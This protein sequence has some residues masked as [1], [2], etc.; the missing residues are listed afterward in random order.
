MYRRCGKGMID[1]R[2]RDGSGGRDGVP[3][4]LSTNLTA[5][6]LRRDLISERPGEVRLGPDRIEW[7]A[8][9]FDWQPGARG[10]DCLSNFTALANSDD[11]D[12]FVEFAKGHGVLGLTEDAIPAASR[13]SDCPRVEGDPEW[14]FE[15][16]AD[17]KAYARNASKLMTLA[18]ELK[19]G[20][21]IDPI[22]L[23]KL[24]NLSEAEWL[25]ALQRLGTRVADTAYGRTLETL[26]ETGFLVA[27]RDA[28]NVQHQRRL[29]A[30]WL[31]SVWLSRAIIYP[32]IEWGKLSWQEEREADLRRKSSKD[33]VIARLSLKS[34][35]SGRLDRVW[36]PENMLF[37]VLT[38]EL[39]TFICSDRRV[40]PCE[41]CGRIY[42]PKRVR[43][44]QA[45]YCFSCRPKVRRATNRNSA[46]ARYER[47]KAE[48]RR[49]LTPSL[50][51]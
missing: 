37:D 25:A 20:R 1:R 39:V 19:H 14:R 15:R 22:R 50:T 9:E 17:W 12:D 11:P 2:E 44:D 10:S 36:W 5:V 24:M 32:A 33:D 13:E 31:E 6:L 49:L 30:D 26:E 47:Q 35:P 45:N 8:T 16:I 7:R 43:T 3:D 27:M 28:P 40:T 38:A 41:R 29:V 21:L 18:G 46:R 42:E 48:R 23:M 4:A 51:P 34:R